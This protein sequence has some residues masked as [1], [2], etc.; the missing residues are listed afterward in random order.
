MNRPCK[1][2][3]AAVVLMLSFAVSLSAQAAY[4]VG[5]VTGTTSQN[6]D[7]FRAATWLIDT[8]GAVADGGMVAHVVYPDDFPAQQ[9]KVSADI[10]ALADDPL[11]K[12]VIVVQAIP[13][14]AEG[15]RRL[16]E[17]RPD[18]VRLCGLPQE[19]PLVIQEVADMVVDFDQVSRGYTI[20]W[21]AKQ[22]G[23]KT[24]VHVSFPRHMAI[25]QLARRRAIF[26]AACKD[27]G[28]RFASETAPDPT[29]AIGM[30]GAQRFITDNV[31]KWLKKYA[32]NGVDRVC[33]FATNDGQTEPLIRELLK[34]K[35]GVFVESDVPSP[36]MGYP[37]ALG[38]DLSKEG[39]DFEAI[40]RTIE[41]AVVE[42]GGAGRFG[43]WKFS[44]NYSVTRGL[45]VF[46]MRIAEGAARKDSTEG[47]FDA[48]GTTTPG[49]RWYGSY[50]TDASTG[51]RAKNQVTIF[52]DTYVMGD[53]GYVLPTTSQKIDPKYTFIK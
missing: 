27:L 40:V 22:L 25:A 17:K 8:Y 48:L 15:F 16:K 31:A 12:A 33:M 34:S 28:L 36:L 13:G 50:Y 30:E 38:I 47:L 4:H 18:I 51:L 19:D 29:T 10:A 44:S 21:A 39:G 5:V 3:S 37:G 6:E 32:P 23:A 2:A 7:E 43:T 46:G 14:T 9:E 11:M 49:V 52:M 35:N 26:Q 53:P 42:K 24:F 20:V 1:V 41:A 45:A